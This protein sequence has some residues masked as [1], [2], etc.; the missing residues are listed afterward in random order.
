MKYFHPL[1][2]SLLIFFLSL[3]INN[4]H[5]QNLVVLDSVSMQP[6]SDVE[7]STYKNG[8]RSILFTNSNGVIK[9]FP[10]VDS[11]RLEHAGFGIH[12]LSSKELKK[13]KHTI[14]LLPSNYQL[15][16][17]HIR[18]VPT[19]EHQSTL[20]I[21]VIS[22][23][24][25]EVQFQ[26]PQT[27]ADLVGLSNNVFIQKSQMGGGSPMIRGF[28]ANNVL[29]VVDGV[30]MNN[31]IFRDGNLQNII[32]IDPGIINQTEILLGP[33]SVMYGSDA[34]GGVMSFQ[35]KIPAIEDGNHYNGNVT[36]RTASANKEN[37][38]H[39]DL[40]YGQNKFSAL[41]SISICN[42]SNLTMGSKGPKEYQRLTFSE[43]NGLNDSVIVSDRPNEQY[44]SGYTQFNL[45]QKFRYQPNKKNDIVLHLGL[46]TTSPI[47]RYDRLIQTRNGQLRYGDWY[48]GPQKWMQAN[49]RIKH[50]FDHDSTQK[51][52]SLADKMVATLSFQ[53]FGESRYD[54][55]LFSKFLNARIENVKVYGI[56][57]DFD[58]KLGKSDVLYG[59]ETI[60]NRV[61]SEA[62]T[63]QIDSGLNSFLDTRYPDGSTYLTNAA[64]A[65]LFRTVSKRLTISAGGRYSLINLNAPF[66]DSSQYNFSFDEI[67]Y[68]TSSFNGSLGALI[69][70]HHSNVININLG[71]G[72]RAPNIDDMTKIF[73]PVPGK[74]VVPNPN[75]LPEIVY[76]AEVGV[77]QQIGKN[78]EFQL[79]VY[80]SWIDQLVTRGDYILNGQD[81]LVY[82]GEK[83]Q[84]Q[85]LVNRGRGTIFGIETELKW[86]INRR[87]KALVAYNYISG[88][89]ENGE[90]IRHVTPN[91]GMASLDYQYRKLH[92]SFYSRYNAELSNASM[93]PSE[94]DK[95]Y[96]YAKDV[97]GLP[98]SPAWTTIN[99][100][101]SLSYSQVV[102]FNIGLE[103]ITDV[104]YRPYSSGISA[105]GR[106]LILSINGKF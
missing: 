11:I 61:G 6:I 98:Y 86:K 101:A 99:L 85:A 5:G 21:K 13:C 24:I 91:F 106:N 72:F 77:K 34:M 16:T 33:G 12:N 90:A 56:N 83:S 31:A 64:Y 41:S 94:K 2:F 52:G 63:L 104:R 18:G 53:D 26:N 79:S 80:N 82:D 28:S 71:S 40:S 74:V 57:L 27:A 97:N 62:Y 22:V 29:I 19:E 38:W 47:P 81:S 17:L 92:I 35:T 65:S 58:K 68:T 84:I 54:R 69:K 3:G 89:L 70:L 88:K 46:A 43:Y 75:L 67:T 39:V 103:N 45:N 1:C 9:Q 49:L 60:Y 10:D 48:Y 23:S 73:D 8:I 93:S 96:I 30:R 51:N 37:S 55:A 76:S 66:A 4:A 7:V 102:Q 59:V 78:V 20:P 100:K 36:L 32:S 87:F 95:A 50:E 14:Y 25:K 44:F 105:A 42:Y 15:P